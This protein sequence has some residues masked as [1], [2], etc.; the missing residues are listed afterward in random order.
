[1]YS[2]FVYHYVGTRVRFIVQVQLE[3]ICELYNYYILHIYTV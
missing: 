2:I 1:M 3:F